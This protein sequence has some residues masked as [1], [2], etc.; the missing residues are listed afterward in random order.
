VPADEIPEAVVTVDF[1][2]LV[3][4]LA[5]ANEAQ[6]LLERRNAATLIDAEYVL[7]PRVTL[8]DE[9]R[10]LVCVVNAPEEA[11]RDPP[12]I[13]AHWYTDT[14]TESLVETVGD[15]TPAPTLATST[16]E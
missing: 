10:R 13:L 2:R 5:I 14:L 4:R 3:D 7:Q 1:E 15:T 8:I 6:V 16:T 9:D 11:R 12:R